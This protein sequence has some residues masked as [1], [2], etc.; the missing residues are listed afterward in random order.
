MA[1]AAKLGLRISK[2]WGE[3]RYDVVVESGGRFIRIQ[4][5]STICRKRKGFYACSVKPSPTSRPYRRGE[6]DFVAAYLIPEDMW[7]I[8]PAKVVVNGEGGARLFSLHRAG[9]ANTHRTKRLGICCAKPRGERAT[10]ATHDLL[11]RVAQTL[12]DRKLGLGC[13]APCGLFARDGCTW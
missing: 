5:K 10:D 12:A 6:F 9:P 13:P 3:C 11:W 4:V 8:F 2:P 1:N 7:Y